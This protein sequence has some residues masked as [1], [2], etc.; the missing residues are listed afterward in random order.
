M[1]QPQWSPTLTP[2]AMMHTK[3]YLALSGANVSG[4][5]SIGGVFFFQNAFD[6]VT[7]GVD[8]VA[9]YKMESKYGATVLTGSVNYNKTRV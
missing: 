6:T 7:E 2:M 5:E 9:T 8:V 3:N 1:F 4:A